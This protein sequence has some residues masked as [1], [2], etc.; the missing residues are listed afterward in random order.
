[1]GDIPEIIKDFM[2]EHDIVDIEHFLSLVSFS[3]YRRS[4]CLVLGK[5]MEEIEDLISKIKIA[6]PEV[7]IKSQSHDF[8]TGLHFS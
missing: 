4:L 8:S 5:S 1:M 7:K 6:Y 3:D 2:K